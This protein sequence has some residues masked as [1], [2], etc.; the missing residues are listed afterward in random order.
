MRNAAALALTAIACSGTP[1]TQSVNAA[2]YRG[3]DAPI[4][5][6]ADRSMLYVPAGTTIVGSTPQEREQAY[7]DYKRTSGNDAARKNNW[8]ERERARAAI[9]L[10]AFRI[11]PTPVTNA[12]YA[13][14]I[15]DTR[16]AAPRID[17]ATWKKQGFIQRYATQVARF[18][19]RGQR[20]P[21]RREDH[22]VVLV[23]WQ[24]ARD[25]CAWRA[26]VVGQPRRLPTAS[27]YEKAARG[28]QGIVYPW[29]NSFD[30]SKLNSHVEGAGDTTAVGSF[31]QGASPYGMLDAAGN[32]FQ[33]TSTPWPHRKDAMTVKG[34]A[35]D[36]YG[37]VG[38]G[39]SQHGRRRWVRHA[40]VGFRCAGPG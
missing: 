34:S 22:P 13:E 36:D 35:W 21:P 33:W 38:R 37:G 26:A 19:W 30:P 32:V 15:D 27:E 31:T 9:Q 16:R 11:D 40:I 23:T 3:G 17:E 25:Y 10:A 8:F 5:R 2:P 1:A 20:P 24:D 4:S 6:A 14:F 18:N 28:A 7:Q 29:G 39:A 12:A